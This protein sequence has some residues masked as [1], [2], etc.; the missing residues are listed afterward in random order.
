MG[1]CKTVNGAYL[2]RYAP[3]LVSANSVTRLLAFSVIVKYRAQ[4]T[5]PNGG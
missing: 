2:Y 5:T 4:R 1:A 3:F